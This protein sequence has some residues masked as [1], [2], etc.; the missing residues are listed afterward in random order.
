MYI[1][2]VIHHCYQM[3]DEYWIKQRFDFDNTINP[4]NGEFIHFLSGEFAQ[5]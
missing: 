2:W 1:T 5:H 4:L 3:K